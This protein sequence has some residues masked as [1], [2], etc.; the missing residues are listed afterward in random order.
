MQA[1]EHAFTKFGKVLRTLNAE[2][3][4]DI[5]IPLQGHRIGLRPAF[6][7]VEVLQGS[8]QSERILFLPQ[9]VSPRLEDLDRLSALRKCHLRRNESRRRPCV[10]FCGG[11]GQFYFISTMSGTGATRGRRDGGNDAGRIGVVGG[12]VGFG[13][14]E[15]SSPWFRD[16]GGSRSQEGG[17]RRIGSVRPDAV[18]ILWAS[19]R[20]LDT[21]EQLRKPKTKH[22]SV[23]KSA[24]NRRPPEIPKR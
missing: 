7:R 19:R 22:D 16:W 6:P 17:N 5:L 12:D 1:S 15:K 3:I 9:Q 8:Q 13:A 24:Y 2:T 4:G 10:D 21:V 11:G 14:V 20:F 23:V 18:E